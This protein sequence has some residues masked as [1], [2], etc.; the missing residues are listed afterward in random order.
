MLWTDEYR[1]LRF[2]ITCSRSN[3]CALWWVI[4]K[5]LA[6]ILALSVF[7][8]CHGRF[9]F[10]DEPKAR[11]EETVDQFWEYV[12]DLS[13]KAEGMRD[14]I[15]STQLGR[16]LDTLISDSMAELQMYSDDMQSK[17]GPYAQ[18][19]AER[20]QG[21][22]KLLMNKLQTHM[23]EAK[24]RVTEYG[25]EL[26]TM[27]EQNADDVKNRVNSYVRKLKKRLSKDTQEINKK[28]ATY[29]EEVQSRTAQGVED[30]RERLAPYF[31]VVRQN[32]EGKFTTLTELLKT[33][34]EDMKEKLE[35]QLEELRNRIEKTN[36][37]LRATIQ[38]KINW[39]Q[40][41][42]TQIQ[43]KKLDL[44]KPKSDVT[45]KTTQLVVGEFGRVQLLGD[46]FRLPVS[47]DVVLGWRGTSGEHA[48]AEKTN[49]GVTCQK[50][51]SHSELKRRVVRVKLLKVEEGKKRAAAAQ[52]WTLAQCAQWTLQIV[53]VQPVCVLVVG[54]RSPLSAESAEVSQ[55]SRVEEKCRW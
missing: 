28:M 49:F 24:D 54:A 38:D 19:T 34:A 44:K 36:E 4:M 13:S 8:G 5:F 39:F 16:E 18:E 9:L 42:T 26:Q 46:R 27:V 29:F 7:S 55:Q 41:L 11:W 14:N 48:V 43:E 21:D 33:Q 2:D 40:Q 25:Q 12:A 50:T 6:V 53:S 15:K 31:D 3:L 51:E 37:N 20:F 22:L 30:V 47:A 52:P 10:Q 1:V 32:A 17:F 35:A 23:E 45:L